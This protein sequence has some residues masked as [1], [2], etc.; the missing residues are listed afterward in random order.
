[1]FHRSALTTILA[2]FLSLTIGISV[3]A[4]RPSLDSG[5]QLDG[6]KPYETAQQITDVFGNTAVYGKLSG[7]IPID[8]YTFTPDRDGEQTIGLL[9]IKDEVVNGS[10]PILILMDPTDAT[11]PRE[12]GLPVPTTGDYHSALIAQETTGRKFSEPLLFQSYLVSAEQRIALQKDKTYYLVVLD[13]GRQAERYV[14]KFGDS[15]VWGGG[16]FF[17]NTGTWFKIK[18]DSFAGANP[19]TGSVSLV[20]MLFLL[21]G[22]MASF[23][24]WLILQVFS[25]GANRSK[26]SAYLLVKLQ[27]FSRIITWVSLWFVV[28]GGYIYFTKNAT[29]GLP[30]LAILSFIPVLITQLVETFTLNPQLRAV[31]VAKR[32]AEIPLPLRKKLFVAF[33]INTLG[34]AATIAF[35]CMYFVQK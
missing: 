19:F 29:F 14:V 24:I 7:D 32:E 6:N 11:E 33:V 8:I 27:P 13:P 16:T 1:M 31:D 21:L 2:T 35:L 15:K 3:A 9:T 12:L 10:D 22:I 30:F 18:T 23:G 17:S 26:S 34:Y 4:A 20:G 28:V 5:A 25:L